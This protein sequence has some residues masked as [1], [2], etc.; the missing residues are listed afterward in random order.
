MDDAAAYE[1]E[2]PEFKFLILN[3]FINMRMFFS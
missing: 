3:Q 2:K 1:E